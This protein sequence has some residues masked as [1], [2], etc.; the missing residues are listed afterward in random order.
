MSSSANYL[1]ELILSIQNEVQ[2]AL[3]YISETSSSVGT[4]LGMSPAVMGIENLRVKLPFTVELEHKRS[5]A[6][7]PLKPNDLETLQKNLISRKGFMFDRGK[8]G[9]L[10]DYTKVKVTSIQAS[11]ENQAMGE[12]EIT[13]SPLRR[14]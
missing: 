3:D 5:S 8:T 12:I 1:T 11:S 6:R 13:F 4:E 10:A 9:K 14:E 2:S 7:T